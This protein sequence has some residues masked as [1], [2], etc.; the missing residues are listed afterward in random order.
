M[1][2]NKKRKDLNAT[3]KLRLIDTYD[4]LNREACLKEK[5]LLN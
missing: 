5:L 3:E 1:S 2:V 4:K